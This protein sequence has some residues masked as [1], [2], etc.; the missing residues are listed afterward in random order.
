MYK[1]LNIYMD[2]IFIQIHILGQEKIF[3]LIKSDITQ[4][5]TSVDTFANRR[6][7]FLHLAL[8]HLNPPSIDSK[9]TSKGKLQKNT[10]CYKGTKGCRLKYKQAT[11]TMD[12]SFL[13]LQFLSF[14]VSKGFL[15]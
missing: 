2:S 13:S 8:H 3:L 9:L 15:I 5:T 10:K 4:V 12:Y 6:N 14:N 1:Q 7:Q 11:T